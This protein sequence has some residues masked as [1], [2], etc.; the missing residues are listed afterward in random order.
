M[1]GD[2]PLILFTF[3]GTAIAFVAVGFCMWVWRSPSS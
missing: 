1:S 2:E 3:L